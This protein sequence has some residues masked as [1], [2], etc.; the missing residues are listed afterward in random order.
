MAKRKPKNVIDQSN[1]PIQLN[2]A[3]LADYKSDIDEL[4][5]VSLADGKFKFTMNK[6]FRTTIIDEKLIPD[7]QAALLTLK[8]DNVSLDDI[9]DTFR[10]LIM[11]ILKTFT[12]LGLN[13]LDMTKEPDVRKLVAVAKELYD[14]EIFTEIVSNI[15]ESELLKVNKQLE[16]TKVASNHMNELFTSIAIAEQ[17]KI[18][19]ENEVLES[20]QFEYNESGSVSEDI[21]SEN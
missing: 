7:V 2:L 8:K 12:N 5:T 16:L 1:E 20:E 13:H 17:E 6:I 19:A 3:V 21:G 11:C 10:I 14:K 4:Q 15:P 9:S 18:D